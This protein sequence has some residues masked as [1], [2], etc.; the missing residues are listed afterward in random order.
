MS[1]ASST[2]ISRPP[3]VT[4]SCVTRSPGSG[5]AA[6]RRRRPE[7]PPRQTASATRAPQLQAHA[8]A[9]AGPGTGGYLAALRPRQLAHDIQSEANSAEPA[10]IAGL[11]LHKPLEDPLMLP[12]RDADALVLHGDFDPVACQPGRHRDRAA[13]RGV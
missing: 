11:A 10:P 6:A 7:H 4:R 12:R 3:V 2:A 8:R 5:S 1:L 9:A 13:L